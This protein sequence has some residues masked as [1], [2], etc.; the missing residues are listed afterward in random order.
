[1]TILSIDVPPEGKDN[2]FQTSKGAAMGK[3]KI[4]FRREL[5]AAATALMAIS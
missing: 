2:P 5:L 1:M 3:E 4:M